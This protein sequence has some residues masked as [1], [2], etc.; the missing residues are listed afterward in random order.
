[1]SPETEPLS[2][3]S[4]SRADETGFF[5][6]QSVS[7]DDSV[8]APIESP[9]ETPG[10][11]RVGDSVF[12]EAPVMVPPAQVATQPAHDLRATDLPGRERRRRVRLQARRV[13]RIV[14]HIEPWSVLKIS[15]IFYMCLWVILMIAGVMLWGVAVQSGQVEN[16]ENFITDLFALKE[17]TFNAD[18]IFRGFALAGLVLAI[19]GTA[20]NV[21]LCVLFNLIS[22]LT[23]GL[24]ITV[25]EEE[26]ARF[27]PRRQRRPARTTPPR[28]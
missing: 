19:A 5:D 7:S 2:S 24:R 16:V 15:I 13:R 22:D 14:R 10:S 8:S 26:S 11:S 4:P 27:R 17:F 28:V 18:R 25:I 23:G 12:T 6:K 1:M 3:S 9:G 21:L 20:F